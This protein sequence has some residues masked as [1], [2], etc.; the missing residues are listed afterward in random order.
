MNISDAK[1]LQNQHQQQPTE[2]S[3]PPSLRVLDVY[4]TSRCF[5][6]S[7][8]YPFLNELESEKTIQ[9]MNELDAKYYVNLYFAHFHGQWPFLTRPQ[10]SPET[11]PPILVLAMV[12]CT[13]RMTEEKSLMRLAWLIHAHLHAIFVTQMD[14]WTVKEYSSHRWPIATYQAILLFTIFTIT[15][16]DYSE[17]FGPNAEDEEEDVLDRIYPI[18][19]RLVCTCR[20]QRILYYPSILSQI[21]ED[22]PLVYKFSAAEELKYFA[23]TLFK[24]D[25]ILSKLMHLDQ[26]PDTS[27]DV[28]GGHVPLSISELQFPPPVNN[29]LW[30]TDG[31]RE[32]LRRRAR[33]CRDPSRSSHIY[34]AIMANDR[35]TVLNRELNPWICDILGSGHVDGQAGNELQM[36]TTAKKLGGRRRAWMGLG[37]WLGYLVGLDVG[38][39]FS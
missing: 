9:L 24:V 32:W 20:V 12:I 34:G 16:N 28:G 8:F 30:E 14:N 21:R 18:F 39:A 7:D 2:D 36:A 13:L 23:L 38:S 26:V 10:F 3:T 33:Q 22:D 27:S 35:R 1:A 19:T 6:A 37:P 31:I 17:V 5:L 4:R 25:N 11:E 29:Y 15:A